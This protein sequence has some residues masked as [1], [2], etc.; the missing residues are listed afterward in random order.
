[1]PNLT[2]SLKSH[3][4]IFKTMLGIATVFGVL[5]AGV[6]YVAIIGIS[7]DASGQ[8][9]KIAALLTESLGREVRFEGAMQYEVSAK[10][11]LHV[12]GLHIANATGFPGSEFASLGDS[13]LELNLWSLLRLRLEVDELTGREVQIRLQSKKDG[14]NNW[15]FKPT[16]QNK[17]ANKP[18]HA[19]N[20]SGMDLD[21]LLTR[22]DIKR[23][24]LEDLNLEFI[25]PNGTSHFFELQSL[26]AHFP[27]GEPLTLALNGTVEKKY[28]YKLELTGGNVASLVRGDNAWPIDLSLGFM[29]SKLSLK[30]ELS[31]KTGELN[32]NVVTD[33][34]GEFERLLQTKSPA[35]GVTRLS[36][37]VKYAPGKMALES[38]SGAMGKTT[39]NGALSLDYSDERPK[40]SGELTLPVLDLRPF[41]TGKAVTQEKPAQSLSEM[42]R[43]FAK[44][45]FNLKNLNS[46]DADLTLHVEKWINIPGA[47]RD[48]TLRVKLDKGRLSVPVAATVADVTLSGN[49]SADATISPARFNLS[50]GTHH[51]SLGNLAGLLL[52]MND[53]RGQLGRFDL[54][55]AA[56]GDRGSELM[57][58][59]DV[60]LAVEKANLTYGNEAGARPVRFSL[61]DFVVALPEGKALT[62]EAHGSLLDKPFSATLQSGSLTAIM[63]E[64]NTPVDFELLAG[65][66]KAEIHAILQPPTEKT[67]S[68]IAF[69]L[70]APHSGEIAS[71]L[72]LKPGVDEPI[73]MHGNFNL[74]SVSWHLADF[75]VQLGH[76]A[77][78]ADV[79]RSLVNG[80]PLLK[81]QLTGDII[82][83]D[84]LGSML[85]ASKDSGV[86]AKRTAVASLIDI[87]IL[88]MGINM[89]DAD[90]T[91]RIKRITSTS[92]LAVRDLAFDGQIRGGMM[93]AS[94]FEAN[95]GE[96]QFTGAI[97]L[98]LR[99]Q[100]PHSVL[101]LSS[102]GMN[103]GSV[104]KKLGLANN[105]DVD[106]DNL[107][108]QLDLHSSRLGKLLAQSD[109]SLNF[110]H[111]HLTLHDVNTGGKMVI[112][113]E[114]GEL[115]SA[116][117]AP[118]S[119]SLRGSLD[120][121]PISIGIET[122]KAV[123]LIN[124]KLSVPFKLDASLS[125]ANVKLSGD[126][127]RPFAKTDI[128]M[129]LEMNGSR[130]DNLNVLAHTSLPPWGPWS[131][132]GKFHMSPAGYEVSSLLLKVGSSELNGH[133]EIDTKVVPPR[134]D[135]ELTA[136]SIQLDDFRFGAWSPE[137][138]PQSKT[139][140]PDQ[141][142][143]KTS[144]QA[145]QMLSPAVLKRQN[146]HLTVRVDQVVSGHDVLGNGNLDAKLENGHAVIGPVRVNT[147]GG[148]ASFLM[149]YEPEEKDIAFSLRAEASH[150]DYGILARRF[151][152]KSEMQG[153]FSL[154]VNISARAQYMSELLRYGKGNI[155]FAVWPQ[156][157][158]SG[159][160]DVWAV[161]V[162]M[163]LLPA[164]DS[165]NASVVNCAIG[166]FVLSD[167]R[168]SDKTIL[169]DTSRMRVT[170]KGGVDLAN[171]E[172]QLYM[173]PRSK[174][175]Q[176]LSFSI[177]VELSGKI[178]DFHVGVSPLDLLETAGQLVT[179]VIWVPLQ[180]LFGKETPSDGRDV[181][182]VT[183][184]K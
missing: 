150:F 93:S 70:S 26:V 50:L 58:S 97:L 165:S 87:P 86:P 156:N 60:R 51:S 82:D 170:G 61:D 162:L 106:V 8:R 76:S 34:P 65:A 62:G 79:Q 141:E 107:R 27:V 177:P 12:G 110:E 72:G 100:Q 17:E 123:D 19:V 179:S 41:M 28:P 114:S 14:S 151:D 90:I 77:L 103:I 9:S 5:L 7:I 18:P 85:P 148:S 78:Y 144:K 130:L 95:V 133:G 24:S 104:L 115:K 35:V 174:T 74:N 181:C 157:M 167:G 16:L 98:D 25:G 46:A 59:L 71:W 45:T 137:K 6:L 108:L 68:E 112:A 31:D 47:V 183:D 155:D 128:E 67:G 176:F 158:K 36:G 29:S 120:N 135:I 140:M 96:N 109:L 42:Y 105:I 81:L 10:P 173:Q 138:S 118:V 92:P 49:A 171:E 178:D 43:E 89:A 44:A 101:W 54:R 4:V 15:A 113:I 53:I 131:A 91:V 52:K 160:L 122:A 147:P 169:I 80:K 145:Q 33:D 21:N 56:R 142:N 175:P 23:V 64:S 126:I 163:A 32:F 124:P 172:I 13:R 73:D 20:G 125:G 83:V 84:E 66:A 40:V 75:A 146:A 184:F 30:G 69:Q 99:S 153:T 154:N 119:L 164:I 168:L 117:G 111:G 149:G 143:D 159:L 39:L 161:N 1:M 11:S 94:P 3:P 121:A 166:R 57:Q 48:A 139:A 88:P 134:I 127:D 2:R 102:A 182:S 180:T 22:L 38:L 116:A 63:Q 152:K 129:A 37:V 132:T 55:I 136:P